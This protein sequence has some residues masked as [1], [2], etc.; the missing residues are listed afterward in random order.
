MSN[1]LFTP[2]S[3]YITGISLVSILVI[4]LCLSVYYY[5]KAKDIA[6]YLLRLEDLQRKIAEA[7]TTLEE[8]KREFR[9][10][11]DGMAKA[12]KL[13]ADGKIAEQWLTDNRFKI[14]VL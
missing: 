1:I 12:D 11:Q 7:Q 10:K 2:T 9:D 14:E 5:C 3:L 4:I 6:P 8:I 13:I